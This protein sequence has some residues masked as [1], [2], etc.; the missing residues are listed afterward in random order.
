MINGS[1]GNNSEYDLSADSAL[2][3][4]MEYADR[5]G[6][7]QQ[8]P[9]VWGMIRSEAKRE[10]ERE[11][12]AGDVQTACCSPGARAGRCQRRSGGRS[13]SSRS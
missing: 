13:R 5:C 3:D 8:P 2:C 6:L 10:R 9:P 11:R 12:E 4:L 7:N 1:S